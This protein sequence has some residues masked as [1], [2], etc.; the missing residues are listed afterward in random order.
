[1]F[2][3]IKKRLLELSAT[4]LNYFAVYGVNYRNFISDFTSEKLFDDK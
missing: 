2:K 4:L 3:R 1:M